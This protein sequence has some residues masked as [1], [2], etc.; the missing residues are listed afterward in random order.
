MYFYRLLYMNL[1]ITTNQKPGKGIQRERNS[2]LTLNS[3]QVTREGRKR[4]RSKKNCKS[5]WKTTNR[6]AISTYLS[7]TTLN[8]NE[9]NAPDIEW[10]NGWKNKTHVCCLPDT[11]FRYKDTHRLKVRG[12]EKLFRADG[13]ERKST[14]IRQNRL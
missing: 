8:V 1:M 3:H 4:R 14:Y 11:Q 9:S 12:W 13:N 6:M 2:N 5:Y 10:L 7:I